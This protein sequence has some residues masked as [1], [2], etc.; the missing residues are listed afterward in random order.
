MSQTPTAIGKYQIIREIARSNDIVYEAYD[1]LMDRRVALKELAIPN[2]STPAQ[3]QDRIERF[4]REARAAGR[5]AHPHIMTVYDVGSEG[6]KHFMA[7]EYLDGHNLRNELDTK[8]LVEHSK[9]IEIISAVLEGLDH[10]HANG[11]VHRD[12]KPDNI[13]LTTSGIKITDFGIARL[14][15][16]PNLTIDGQVFGTPSYMSPE[17]I[18]GGEI[19]ARS[20]VFSAGVLLYEMLGGQK[21]FQGDS[22]IAITHAILNNEPTQPSAVSYPLW[23]VIQRALDKSPGL[24]FSSAREMIDAIAQAEN[25]G[26]GLV[27]NNYAPPMASPYSYANPYAPP[28]VV[29]PPPPQYTPT[30]PPATYG[31]NPYIPGPHQTGPQPT[32]FTPPPMIYYPPPPRRPMMRPE[33]SATLKRVALIFIVMA[34]FFA[35]LVAILTVF[36]SQD[37]AQTPNRRVDAPGGPNAQ[38]ISTAEIPTGSSPAPNSRTDFGTILPAIPDGL[39]WREYGDLGDRYR[40]QSE[41]SELNGGGRQSYMERAAEAYEK[42]AQAANLEGLP[43]VIRRTALFQAREMA[44]PGTPVWDR[45]EQEVRKIE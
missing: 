29:A 8:G 32:G 44:P 27:M 31:Y 26:D 23:Q 2:G 21:P 24:R 4:E 3:V 43:D 28:V 37:T 38:P 12:I 36:T 33:T 17:Q 39:S 25:M 40:Q 1:P 18:R 15:F 34:T 20:D 9:A 42:Q 7:M 30:A 13:Q 14:T 35:M 16:Q 11:V 5:L 6:E 22:V 41:S 10:A 19:D 45:I